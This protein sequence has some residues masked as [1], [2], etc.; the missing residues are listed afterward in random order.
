MDTIGTHVSGPPLVRAAPATACPRYFGGTEKPLPG[1]HRGKVTRRGATHKEL[2]PRTVAWAV[3]LVMLMV[4]AGWSFVG[5]SSY[6]AMS[7]IKPLPTGDKVVLDVTFPPNGASGVRT[8]ALLIAVPSGVKVAT[9]MATVDHL[10]R[11]RGWTRSMC[12][13]KEALC[14]IVE[15]SPAALHNYGIPSSSPSV[16]RIEIALHKLSQPSFM[17]LLVHK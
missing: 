11:S 10:L 7:A 1:S 5:G 15:C 17:I 2:N 13:T 6:S 16:R 4:E 14:A 12:S 8:R 3:V 9:G